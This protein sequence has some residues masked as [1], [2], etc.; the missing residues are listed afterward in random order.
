MT[1][2]YSVAFKQKMVQRL[3]GKD[4]VSALQLSKEAGVSV[5]TNERQTR[6]V[7]E[8]AA[9]GTEQRPRGNAGVELTIPP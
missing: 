7:T 4:A 9:L 5:L 6:P 2:P 8:A 3:T 1:Q